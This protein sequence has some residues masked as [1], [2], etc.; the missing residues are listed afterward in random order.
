MRIAM[1]VIRLI[2]AVPY[3]LFRMWWMGNHSTKE[4]TYEFVK[5]CVKRANDKGK[6]LI[7]VYGLEN[8][9]EKDGYVLFPN[10][11]SSESCSRPSR[12]FRRQRD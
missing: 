8:L 5:Y 6:V 10:Q 1:M 4:K 3:Y 7:D 12:G 2:Y 11:D 9:P